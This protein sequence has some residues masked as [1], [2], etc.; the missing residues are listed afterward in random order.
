MISL[1]VNNIDRKYIISFF[2]IVVLLFPFVR[3]FNV[4]Y[5]THM[6]SLPL[7]L[8]GA[9]LL[10]VRHM[11]PHVVWLLCV[12]ISPDL[13]FP[14]ECR[15]SASCKNID[16]KILADEMLFYGEADMIHAQQAVTRAR[17][18]RPWSMGVDTKLAKHLKSSSLLYD[19]I[20]TSLQGRCYYVDRHH[21]WRSKLF[22]L[23]LLLRK[24]GFWKHICLIMA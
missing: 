7:T 11:L 4:W 5:Q 21:Y 17:T 20:I 12:V 8:P 3:L 22:L 18:S 2:I 13:T 10:R 16:M 14:Q 9:P 23:L 15:P 1:V 24:W 19:D 6:T